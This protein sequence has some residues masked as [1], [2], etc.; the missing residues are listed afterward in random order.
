M[1]M[2]WRLRTREKFWRISVEAETLTLVTG[3]L[4]TGGTQNHIVAK[5]PEAALKTAQSLV[6]QRKKDG[7]R[8][9]D[10]SD[11]RSSSSALVTSLEPA[12][13]A[14][15]PAAWAVLADGLLESGDIARGEFV[16]HQLRAQKRQRGSIGK[17]RAHLKASYDALVGPEL[18]S[19]HKQV[20]IDW[21]NG[22]AHTVKVWSGPYSEPIAH[23]LESVFASPACRFLR[24]LELGSPGAEGR[25]GSALR[26]LS[27]LTWPKHLDTLSLGAFDVEAAKLADSPWPIIESL[28]ALLPAPQ[29]KSLRVRGVLNTFGRGLDFPAL[30]HLWLM[31]SHVHARLFGDL[32][33]I[34]PGRLRRFE[35]TESGEGHVMPEARATALHALIMNAGVRELA[36]H[37]VPEV[38]RVLALLG[39]KVLLKLEHLDLTDSVTLSDATSLT[40]LAPVLSGARV[41]LGDAPALAKRMESFI[42]RPVTRVESDPQLHSAE[43]V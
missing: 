34:K 11:V 6:A 37:G 19:F 17:M 26:E 31:P 10:G 22:Y 27:S 29:L 14:D 25:Y 23:V 41:E 32:A 40:T 3:A 2:E 8:D 15:D 13:L 9:D 4:G 36:L 42:A 35:L 20:S 30:E 43:S 5:S 16:M 7:Y 38:T 1:V 28:S 33:N 21:R 24:C 39:P 12:L 18:A